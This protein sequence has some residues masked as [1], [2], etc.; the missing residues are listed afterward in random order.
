[1]KRN[2]PAP[3]TSYLTLLVGFLILAA[4]V[5]V[6][7]P[8]PIDPATWTPPAPPPLEGPTAPNQALERAERF[9]LG[10]LQGPED[11]AVD[12][13]GIVWAGLDDG[14]IVKVR[15][16]GPVEAPRTSS[17]TPAAGRWACTSTPK[18]A[19]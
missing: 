5:F 3:R 11:L 7:W 9:G 14:R 4:G 17:T 1:M 10:Q 19:W 13:D 16:D 15:L 2:E 12:A 18:A 6:F 8:S